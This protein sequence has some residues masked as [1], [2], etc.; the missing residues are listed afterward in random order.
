MRVLIGDARELAAAESPGSVDVII[1]DPPY[2]D[3]SLAWDRWPVGWLDAV[4]ALLKPSGSLWCFGSFRMFWTHSQQFSRWHVAQEIVWEK[5]NGSG[6]SAD[7]F[8]RVHELS[9]HFYPKVRTWAEIYKKPVYTNDA[10]ARTVMHSKKRVAHWGS[11]GDSSYLSEDGG[12]RLQRSVIYHP[13]EHGNAIHPTQKPVEIVRQLI[14]YSCPAG[15]H[16]LSPFMGS[17]TDLIAAKLQGCHATGFE[18]NPEYAEMAKERLAADA[19][20]FTE[21]TP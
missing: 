10:T 12:P 5:H 8:R 6:S 2:G 20:L 11:I 13:S 4:E 15:G 3:T 17:G 21:D 9:V 16:V 1:A 14:E 19:P 18:L 7:R